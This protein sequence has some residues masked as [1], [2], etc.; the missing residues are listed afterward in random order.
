[1][2]MYTAREARKIRVAHSLNWLYDKYFSNKLL[3]I[4]EYGSHGTTV[5]ID[6]NTHRAMD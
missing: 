3:F 4:K 1:M 6:Y 2:D 5:I